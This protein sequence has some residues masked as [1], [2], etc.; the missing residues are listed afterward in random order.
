MII[1][2]QTMA[3]TAMPH[4]NGGE[5]ELHAKLFTDEHTKILHGRLEPGASIGLHTHAENFEVIY[6]LEGNGKVLYDEFEETVSAGF[7][8]YCPKSHAHSLINDSDKDLIFFAVIPLK[9]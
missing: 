2:F 5:K 9:A 7:C 6:I 8:H 1:P 4:F 3:K